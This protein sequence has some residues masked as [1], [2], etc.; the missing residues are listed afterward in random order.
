MLLTDKYADKIYGIITCYDRMI[1]Q[2]YIPNWSHADAMTTY[3]KLNGIRIFDYPGFSQPLTEQVRQNAEKIAQENG[4]EIEFIRKLHAFRKD[5]CIQKIIA[6]T[7]KTE[8]LVHIFSA[9]EC[10]NTY[11][12]WH[13]KTT[14][15]TFRSLTRASAFITISI[16]SIGNS[17]SAI[18]AFLH[19]R[20]SGFSFT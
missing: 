16:L 11:K 14:G 10:C 5:D 12:P 19:G 2:G 9:M 20:L 4:I 18:S 7:G 6:E 1:I 15:K 17:V 8:G 3:M 13:D